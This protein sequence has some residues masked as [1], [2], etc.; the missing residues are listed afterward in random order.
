MWIGYSVLPSIR[1]G[2]KRSRRGHEAHQKFDG[3]DSNEWVG[4]GGEEAKDGST[5]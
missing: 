4:F 3:F 2:K 5:P 1:H